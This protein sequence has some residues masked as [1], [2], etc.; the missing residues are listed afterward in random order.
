MGERKDSWWTRRKFHVDI[1]KGTN[2]TKIFQ[3]HH[4]K[5]DLPSF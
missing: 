1:A 5:L 2:F 3:L 4:I